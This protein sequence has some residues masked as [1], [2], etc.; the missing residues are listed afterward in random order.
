MI[1][2]HAVAAVCQVERNV[3]VRL[4]SAGAAIAVP[5]FDSLAIFDQRGETFTQ[6]INRFANAQIQAFHH[7]GFM[8]VRIL[9]IAIRFRDT[10]GDPSAMAQEVQRPVITFGDANTQITAVQRGEFIVVFK[11]QFGGVG[12]H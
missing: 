5:G 3:F 2:Q 10:A 11:A 4:L 9:N 7:V 12:L 1:Y 6:A 8:R